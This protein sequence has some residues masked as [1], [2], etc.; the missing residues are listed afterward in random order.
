MMRADRISPAPPAAD[1][2]AGPAP[3]GS[4]GPAV[5]LDAQVLDKISAR[6]S[7]RLARKATVAPE[8]TAETAP[9][10]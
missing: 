6:L 5:A 9:N 8:T 10:G 2:T 7:K 3:P 1:P 4:P